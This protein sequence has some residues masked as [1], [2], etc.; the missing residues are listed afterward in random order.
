MSLT[1]TQPAT[2]AA[3]AA[4]TCIVSAPPFLAP[5]RVINSP[6][7]AGFWKAVKVDP[8]PGA[9]VMQLGV[10][11]HPANAP[12]TAGELI[13]GFQWCGYL[14]TGYHTFL[15][16][17]AN[18]PVTANASGGQISAKLYMKID[19]SCTS[20]VAQSRCIQYLQVSRYVIG[21]THTISL[22][23]IIQS[24]F[25]CSASPYG[26]IIMA[27]AEFTHFPGL[28]LGSGV[29]AESAAESVAEESAGE[30]LFDEKALQTAEISPRETAQA[31]LDSLLINA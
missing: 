11:P 3:V 6:E 10:D 15:V 20:Q 31:R 29:Q 21:G 8:W 22:G 16:R 26:E 24:A 19:G 18:G 30:S 7:P 1:T 2:D 28:A 23:G 4:S 12:Y 5:W 14:A 9:W 27:R 17:F 13:A 25:Q